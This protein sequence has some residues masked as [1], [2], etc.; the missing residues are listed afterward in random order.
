MEHGIEILTDWGWLYIPAKDRAQADTLHE[1]TKAE[2][3]ALCRRV[4]RLEDGTII[5]IHATE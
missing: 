3:I 1:V 2:N 4:G 5:T